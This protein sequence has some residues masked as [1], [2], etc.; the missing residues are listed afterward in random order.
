MFVNEGHGEAL[1]GRDSSFKLGIL[2][3]V[4]SVVNRESNRPSEMGPLLD[5]FGDLFHGLGKVTNFE[6]KIA[7]D[8]KIQPVS[9][10]LR[11]IPLSQVEA[12]N[13]ELDKMLEADIIEEVKEASPWVS[14]LV[15]APKK[16]GDIRLCFDALI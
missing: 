6:H 10:S 8:P 2:K 5:E 13:N 16:S 15:V 4:N 7:I 12:V 1:L 14:N 9:Q 11:R 3:H